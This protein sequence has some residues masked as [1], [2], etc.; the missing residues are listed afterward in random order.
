MFDKFSLLL[1]TIDNDDR[2]GSSIATKSRNSYFT[3]IHHRTSSSGQDVQSLRVTEREEKIIRK[4]AGFI[5]FS[6][7]NITSP[8]IPRLP[9]PY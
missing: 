2:F 4:V 3:C 8:A 9:S 7:K 6:L 1:V 5:P